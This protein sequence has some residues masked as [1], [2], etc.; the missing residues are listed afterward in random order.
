MALPVLLRKLFANEGYG[1]QLRSDIIPDLSRFYL[2]VNGG[3]VNGVF[4]VSGCPIYVTNATGTDGRVTDELSMSAD[5]AKG[6]K[7]ALLSLRSLADGYNPGGAVLFTRNKDGTLGTML[8][9]RNDGVAWWAGRKLAFQ[10][11]YLPLSGGTMTGRITFVSSGYITSLVDGSW[12]TVDIYSDDGLRKGAKLHLRS[13]ESATQPGS[14][15]LSA[16]KSDGTSIDFYGAPDTGKLFW[17]GD[18]VVTKKEVLPVGTV[19]YFAADY[20]PT[21][22]LL[23]NGAQ[24]SRTTY[25]DLFNVIGTKYGAGDGST[26]FNLPNL[27]NCFVEGYT[28]SGIYRKP[29]LPNIE[30]SVGNLAFAGTGPF[31]MRTD[32]GTGWGPKDGL[33]NNKC[34]FNASIANDI[35]GSS[36]TVQPPA[37]TM[38]PVIK[39]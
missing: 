34:Y 17:N 37:L 9:L 2:N 1:P 5:T 4:F 8:E 23:C 26:T 33:P 28:T 24:I 39:Y 31:I 25:A 20:D 7:G 18:Q 27:V 35:Y 6:K 19:L 16:V 32:L 29:G 12:K 11:D 21:G 30:G 14:F 38:R 13:I 3:N 15:C 22:F 36:T 10:G